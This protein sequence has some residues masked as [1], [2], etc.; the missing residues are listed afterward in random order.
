MH[1]FHKVTSMLGVLVPLAFIV[2]HSITSAFDVALAFM[3]PFHATIGLN[4]II[5][6]YVPR[7][8]RGCARSIALAACFVS[9]VGLVRLSIE[10][11]GLSGA[12]ISMWKKPKKESA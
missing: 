8:I 11:D 7:R 9:M 10:G 2:P 3:L 1:S 4:G 5:D 6:D 12:V